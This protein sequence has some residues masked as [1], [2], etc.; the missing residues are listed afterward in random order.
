MLATQYEVEDTYLSWLGK[1]YSRALGRLWAWKLYSLR[2]CVAPSWLHGV[3][4]RWSAVCLNE[5]VNS[6]FTLHFCITDLL[7]EEPD[8]PLDLKALVFIL[9]LWM[10]FKLDSQFQWLQGMKTE[11]PACCLPKAPQSPTFWKS[12][13][14]RMCFFFVLPYRAQLPLPRFRTRM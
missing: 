13:R 11:I 2:D 8:A 5:T 10:K 1:D 4:G 6:R 3:V 7:M 14:S 12:L 9:C